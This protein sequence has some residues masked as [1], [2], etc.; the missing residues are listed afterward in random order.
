MK[1]IYIQQHGPIEKLKAT[2]VDKP[3]LQPDEVLVAVEASGINP[4]DLVSARGG[5]TG[6]VLPRILGRD[7]AGQ[8]V[9]G[10]ADL[11]GAE[12][13]GTGGDLGITR[14]GAHAE[15]LAIPRA[16]AARR[17]TSLSAEAAAVAG[18]PFVTAYSALIPA[19]Q[20][21]R[22][23]WVIVTGAAGAVG[24][25]A[26]QLAKANGAR[27]IALLRD[28][29]EQGIA[30]AGMVDAIALSDNNNLAQVVQDVTGGKGADLALNGVGA[31]VMDTLLGSLAVN[32]RLVIYSSAGGNEF[33]L[34]LGSFYHRQV[35]MVGVN[36]QLLD[37]MQCAA[38]LNQLTPLFEAGSLKPSAIAQRFALQSAPEAYKRVASGKPGKVVLIM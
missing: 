9:E 29:S 17:P 25:A 32:G 33:S 30:Q 27:V 4:S 37:A 23:Q 13:W 38:I 11:I 22:G 34:N 20:L 35:S 26:V 5:F 18:L 36:T 7:F 10:P 19:G 16:A 14:N 6:S 12:V 21:Q 2:E 3:S 31:T 8:V 24:Q 28:A 15:Y 1:A